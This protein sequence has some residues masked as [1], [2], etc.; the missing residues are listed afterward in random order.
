MSSQA[1]FWVNIG[2][3]LILILI[4]IVGKRGLSA[5]S[6]LNVKK[7]QTGK[8][9]VRSGAE[10]KSM[11]AEVDPAETR[12]K[13]LNVMFMYNGHSFDAYEVLGA[14]A[15]A[16]FEMV[17]KFYQQAISKQGGDHEFL[18]AALAAIKSSRQ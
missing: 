17:Q 2:L 3:G 18:E 5:P 7:V 16:S 1:F 6:R 11:S 4:F 9:L 15:G 14:P 12:V 10:F 13:N 8:G